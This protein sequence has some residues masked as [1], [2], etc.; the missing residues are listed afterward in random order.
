MAVASQEPRDPVDLVREWDIP[1]GGD[2][3]GARGDGGLA[4][5]QGKPANG[6]DPMD[7]V[8]QAPSL[9]LANMLSHKSSMEEAWLEA[10]TQAVGQL[11]LLLPTAWQEQFTHDELI[12]LA[13]RVNSNSHG[14]T[15]PEYASTAVG[16]GMFPVT[17][18]INHSCLVS[19]ER[20]SDVFL[21]SVSVLDRMT[22]IVFSESY[23]LDRPIS[24]QSPHLIL[25]Q[26]RP[27]RIV[28]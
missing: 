19:I 26:L 6:T 28:L 24:S 3:G 15:D 7:E 27:H 16:F 2:G 5:D 1:S 9:L 18:T 10:V 4:G 25:Y 23:H 11:H 17:A 22:S 12:S 13:C 8:V 20:V 14:I 21:L